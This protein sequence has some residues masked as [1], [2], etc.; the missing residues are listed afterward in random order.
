[1]STQTLHPIHQKIIAKLG[2]PAMLAAL[3]S[4]AAPKDNTPLTEAVSKLSAQLDTKPN[5][6]QS[7]YAQLDTK[8]GS[9]QSKYLPSAKPTRAADT[10]TSWTWPDDEENKVLVKGVLVNATWNG[11]KPIHQASASFYFHDVGYPVYDSDGH[12]LQNMPLPDLR[13]IVKAM[14]NLLPKATQ[15]QIHDWAAS[16]SEASLANIADVI[17][18]IVKDVLQSV[19][20]IPAF[21]VRVIIGVLIPRI[22]VWIVTHIAELPVKDS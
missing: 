17:Y 21:V 22:V 2:G 6:P 19:F 5:S 14:W 10:D 12:F 8:P 4:S 7:M 9:P 18:D 20:H 3:G 13:D 15:E 16:S 1:M 11:Y